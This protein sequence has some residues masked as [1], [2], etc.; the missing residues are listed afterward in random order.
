MGEPRASANGV[1]TIASLTLGAATLAA[2][3]ATGAAPPSTAALAAA[4]C[5][6]LAALFHAASLGTRRLALA[7]RS[8]AFP[9]RSE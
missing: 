1:A 4:G 5:A 3:T 8:S 6:A 7:R 9:R 2:L